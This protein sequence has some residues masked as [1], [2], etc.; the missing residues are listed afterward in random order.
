MTDHITP[1]PTP[2]VEL[3]DVT[4][5][6]GHV[7]ALRDVSLRIEPGEMVAILGPNGAGKTTAISIM[8]GIRKPTSGEAWMFG[9]DP[10]DLRA[11]IRCAVMLQDTGFHWSLRAQ[12]P[13]KL[14]TCTVPGTLARSKDR[15]L[16]A[17]GSF[18]RVQDDGPFRSDGTWLQKQN[19]EANA[20]SST[21]YIGSFSS[22][23]T[24]P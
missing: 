24:S 4:K 17:R 9:I 14:P 8:L 2:A 22:R 7:E 3:R 20:S 10:Q 13:P 23:Q 16:R 6:F 12:V 19:A 11:R 15:A 18:G 1:P 5:R 21:Q